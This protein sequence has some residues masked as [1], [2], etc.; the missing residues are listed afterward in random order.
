MVQG[1]EGWRWAHYGADAPV[2]S[3]VACSAAAPRYQYH[4]ARRQRSD[5][6]YTADDVS[7]HVE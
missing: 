6:W 4:M 1:G 5:C 7:L 2:Y 3:L